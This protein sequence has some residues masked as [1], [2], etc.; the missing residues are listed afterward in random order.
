LEKAN[1]RVQA[2]IESNPQE[3]TTDDG[4]PIY[5]KYYLNDYKHDAVIIVCLEGSHDLNLIKELEELKVTKGRLLII[6]WKEIVEQFKGDLFIH[7]DQ[8]NY[9]FIHFNSKE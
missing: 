9:S 7:K 1:I 2:L 8:Q 6:S 3:V 5:G 4:I